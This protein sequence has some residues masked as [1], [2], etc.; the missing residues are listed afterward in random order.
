M[1]IMQEKIFQSILIHDLERKERTMSISKW[2][3]NQKIEETLEALLNKLTLEEKI[4]MIHG[5]G[6]FRTAPVE[7]LGIPAIKFSDGPMGVRAEFQN[8]HWKNLD[9]NDDF[10]TYF[11]SNSAI[12]ATWNPELAAASGEVLGEEARGRGKDMILAPGI[13][14]QRVPECGRNFEYMSEDP[15]LVSAMIVPMVEGIQKSD[16]AACVKHFALNQQEIER[17]WVNVEVS[18]ETLRELYLP[19]FEAAVKYGSVHSVMGAYN[20]YKGVHCCENQTLLNEILR[21]E[22][23][24]DGVVVSDWGG[25]HD[26]KAAAEAAIDIE[27][28]VTPDFNEYCLADPLL[29]AVRSGQVSEE[30]IDKKVRNILRLMLRLHAMDQRRK[31]GCVN[32]KKHQITVRETAEESIVLLKNEDQI[33]PLD[34]NAKEKILVV[35]DNAV[36]LHANGGGSA[37]IR[38]LYEIP[39]LLGI[40]MLLGGNADISFAKGYAP[41]KKEASDHNWQENSLDDDALE[42]RHVDAGLDPELL[43]EAVSMAKTADRVIYIGGL[44]HDY[45]IE[46]QDRENLLLPYGQDEL[47]QALLTAN[48]QMTVVMMAGSPVDMSAWKDRVK[49]LVWMSYAGM[50]SGY[51]LA[52]VL[53]GA[54]NPSGHLAQTLPYE[55]RK[56]FTGREDPGSRGILAFPGRPVTEGEARRMNAKLTESYS[57]GRLVGYRYYEKHHIP[58]QFPFG[59]GLSYTTF[60]IESPSLAVPAVL[61]AL[62]KLPEKTT[63]AYSAAEVENTGSR[64]GKTVLQVYVGRQHPDEDEPLWELKGFCK[65]ALAAG[66]KKTEVISLTARDFAHYDTGKKCF[67]IKKDTYEVLIGDSSQNRKSCGTFTVDQEIICVPQ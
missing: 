59:Y 4:G 18:E 38:A 51:A 6:L 17:L 1:H 42:I 5:A 65:S 13:N 15:A 58:V 39:P 66:E 20:L 52:E 36:R 56:Q 19:G 31:P 16:V 53:F 55:N 24:F 64:S 67:V 33:L 57:E 25:V 46:G 26:T 50:E 49:S 32:T 27:M 54:V 29:K 28:S 63:L 44:N 14:I 60:S 2:K 40:K 48:E 61:L 8:D 43:E 7:R 62:D 41:A 9:Q 3:Y 47:I 45:D 37:E 11:P 23:G 22:W 34:P 12:A 21:E 10:V 30:K 35:G